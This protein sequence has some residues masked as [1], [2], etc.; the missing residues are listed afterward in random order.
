[1]PIEKYDNVGEPS[2][3][4]NGTHIFYPVITMPKSTIGKTW[5]FVDPSFDFKGQYAQSNN[6]AGNTTTIDLFE[7]IRELY[8]SY[9]TRC[10]YGC[11]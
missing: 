4:T 11:D 1:M 7:Q 10:T 3:A 2:F 5:N 6:T 9:I 8:Q